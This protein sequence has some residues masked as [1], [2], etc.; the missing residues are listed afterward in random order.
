MDSP[1]QEAAGA[2][3]PQKPG[4]RS[5][6]YADAQKGIIRKEI[7]ADDA[8]RSLLAP[9]QQAKKRKIGYNGILRKYPNM[10]FT[11]NGLR[12]AMERFRAQQAG[13]EMPAKSGRQ[14]TV[15]SEENKELAAQLIADNP[16]QSLADAMQATRLKRTIAQRLVKDI[17]ADDAARSLLAPE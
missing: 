5:K 11:A 3:N 4:K 13:G 6:A 12:D 16:K 17:E 14:R 7:E 15:R 10:G 1:A 2:P 9:E 8:A